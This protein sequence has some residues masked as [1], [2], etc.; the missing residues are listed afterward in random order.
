MP[1]G[2][3]FELDFELDVEVDEIEDDLVLVGAIVSFFFLGSCVD[4]KAVS[5][6]SVKK[7]EW[8]KRSAKNSEGDKYIYLSLSPAQGGTIP[9]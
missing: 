2:V 9:T 8:G 5:W 4:F 3:D 1:S 6:N 7:E